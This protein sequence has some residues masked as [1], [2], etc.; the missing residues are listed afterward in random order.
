VRTTLRQVQEKIEK[1][2]ALKRQLIGF[3]EVG[4]EALSRQANAEIARE[5]RG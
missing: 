3:L 2:E 4:G 1:L 5:L